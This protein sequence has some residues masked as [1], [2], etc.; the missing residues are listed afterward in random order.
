MV[1]GRVRD[2]KILDPHGSPLLFF[3]G[4]YGH[5]EALEG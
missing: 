4:A 2:V 1:L 3:R 5:F